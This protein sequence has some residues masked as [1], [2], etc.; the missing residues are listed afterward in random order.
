MSQDFSNKLYIEIHGLLNFPALQ[1]E[2]TTV[3]HEI[4]DSEQIRMIALHVSDSTLSY[5]RKE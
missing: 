4:D 3:K 5:I 1:L 2:E